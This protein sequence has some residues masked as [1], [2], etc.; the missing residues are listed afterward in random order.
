MDKDGFLYLTGRL[1][2]MIISGGVNIFPLEIEA[3]IMRHPM[4]LDVGVVR[5]PDASWERFRPPS[6]S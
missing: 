1:K 6:S 2:E 5:F 4:V 3:T